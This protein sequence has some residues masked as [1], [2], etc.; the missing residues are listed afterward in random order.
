MC[1]NNTIFATS[2]TC[3]N[4]MLQT[5]TIHIRID[6]SIRI[7]KRIGWFSF[8]NEKWN[9]Q[10]VIIDIYIYICFPVDERITLGCFSLE[11]P[12][13]P[14]QSVPKNTGVQFHWHDS[15]IISWIEF[16]HGHNCRLSQS[17]AYIQLCVLGGSCGKYNSYT[18]VGPLLDPIGFA[19]P[20]T[21]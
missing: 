11:I 12:L 2:K 1:T 16:V 8:R 17:A 14:P 13:Y 15:G 6:I 4:G 20:K 18:R 21:K 10:M 7:G 5:N 3:H 19:M 9:E